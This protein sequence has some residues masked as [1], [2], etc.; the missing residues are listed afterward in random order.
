MQEFKDKVAVITGGASG[1]GLAMARRFAREGMK[2]ALGDIEEE[3]LRR[4]EQ[5]FRRAGVP[6]LAIRTDVSRGHDVERLAEKTL[7]TFGAVHVVCNNAGVGPGGVIWENSTADWEW[8]L[9]VNV[10]GVIHGVRVFVPIMLRQN[11]PCHVVNT[12]SVAGLLSVPGMGVY[13]VSKHAVVTLTECLYHDLQARSAKIGVSLLCPAYVPTGIADSERNRPAALHNAPRP[14]SPEDLERE[15]MM[16]HAV[17]SGRIKPDEVAE[18]VFDAIV[19]ERFYILTHPRIKGA[20]EA[21]VQDIL[22]D[23]NPTDTSRPA[24]TQKN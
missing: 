8:V 9:G 22:E 17:E 12:A 23:R 21:R 2:L 6:V 10:W 13:C 1:L 19:R 20:V 3:P 14:R 18:M 11:T 24:K 15:Q 16:R 7:A 5:E 4:V